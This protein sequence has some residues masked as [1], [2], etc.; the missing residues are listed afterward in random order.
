MKFNKMQTGAVAAVVALTLGIGGFTI[1]K[2]YAA[3]NTSPSAQTVLDDDREVNDATEQANLEAIA[4][5]SSDEAKTI[6]TD[7]N[8]DYTVNYAEL[9]EEDGQAIYAV[10]TVDK[11]GT[12]YEVKVDAVSGNIIKTEKDD[13]QGQEEIDSADQAAQAKI[14]TDDAKTAVMSAHPDYTINQVELEDEDGQIIYAVKATDA[15]NQF[16]EVEVDA[17]NGTI[18]STEAD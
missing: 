2:T 1:S 10:K 9:E 16:Y 4:K 5:I 12:Y 3:N 11:A 17:T 6:V 18:L 15:N 13:D 8:H 7:S 14:T